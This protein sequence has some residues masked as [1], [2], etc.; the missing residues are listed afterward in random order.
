MTATYKTPSGYP[1]H[2]ATEAKVASNLLGGVRGAASDAAGV[3]G[4]LF[5]MPGYQEESPYA[6]IRGK[7]RWV[8]TR[9][10]AM[11]Q[12]TKQYKD[13]VSSPE[14]RGALPAAYNHA[15]MSDKARSTHLNSYSPSMYGAGDAFMD[16]GILSLAGAGTYRMARGPYRGKAMHIP[17][18]KL[19]LGLGALALLGMYG[20]GRATDA[21]AWRRSGLGFT[22]PNGAALPNANGDFDNYRA[23]S[24]EYHDALTRIQAK[25]VV[26][27]DG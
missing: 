12:T 5:R 27:T 1:Q 23:R 22:P 16:A 4:D 20:A 9:P 3:M 15:F 17:K 26:P 6:G 19:G 25:N 24:R 18:G 21:M 10:Q 8:A 2:I 7:L 11:Y 13:V 14:Y